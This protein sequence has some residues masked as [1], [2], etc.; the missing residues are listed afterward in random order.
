[1][2]RLRFGHLP[3]SLSVSAEL[4]SYCTYTVLPDIPE[5]ERVKRQK[6]IDGCNGPWVT[7]GTDEV[8]LKVKDDL[9]I[10]LD[11]VRLSSHV[12]LLLRSS[13]PIP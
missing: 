10:T 3:P 13:I 5:V 12:Y 2:T 9:C 1:M 6:G 4:L 11:F 8:F 7:E